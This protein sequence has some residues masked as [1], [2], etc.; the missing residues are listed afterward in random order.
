M[1]AAQLS[2]AFFLQMAVIVAACRVTGWLAKRYLGQPQVVGEMIA[3]V[4]LG[5]SVLGWLAPGLEAALFPA[6]TKK[7]LFVGAQLGSGCTCSSSG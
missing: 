3:G 4:L 5:P 2:I 7:V 1:T 6:D